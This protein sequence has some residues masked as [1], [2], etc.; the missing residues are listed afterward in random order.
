MFGVVPVFVCSSVVVFTRTTGDQTNVQL[1]F[2]QITK[3]NSSLM[4][5]FPQK[6]IEQ[7]WLRNEK[8]YPF[9]NYFEVLYLYLFT[10]LFFKFVYTQI[11]VVIEEKSTR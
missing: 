10:Y 4:R 9:C 2:D 8:F 11:L 3:D 7:E 6:S 1:F 5:T